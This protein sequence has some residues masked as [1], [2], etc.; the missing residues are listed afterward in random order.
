MPLCGW[1]LVW[2]ACLWPLLIPLWIRRSDRRYERE[3][4]KMIRRRLGGVTIDRVEGG[5]TMMVARLG[6]DHEDRLRKL[7]MDVTTATGVTVSISESHYTV[8][9][10]RQTGYWDVT[11]G[12]TT[13]GPYSFEAACNYMMGAQFGAIAAKGTWG[14]R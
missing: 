10:K 14:D 11:V 3:W 1:V 2:I 8:N 7:A 9:G 5:A 6:G 13:G 12:P 4:A